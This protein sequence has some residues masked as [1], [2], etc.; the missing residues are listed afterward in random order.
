MQEAKHAEDITMAVRQ[1]LT[2]LGFV[3][4]P[5][6]MGHF[7]SVVPL[8]TVFAIARPQNHVKISALQKGV[9]NGEM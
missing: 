5:D 9:R 3:N 2:G 1:D 8:D 4:E 6:R 7:E